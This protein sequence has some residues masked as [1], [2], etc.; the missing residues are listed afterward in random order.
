MTNTTKNKK[1]I[2]GASASVAQ[3]N[4]PETDMMREVPHKVSLTFSD[5][6]S[7]ELTLSAECPQTA[8]Q[9]AYRLYK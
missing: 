5:D 4:S 1:V 3:Q 2:T 9:K 7:R 6:T 8:I